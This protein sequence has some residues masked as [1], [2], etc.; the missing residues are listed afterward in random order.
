M[1]GPNVKGYEPNMVFKMK[2]Q[3]AENEGNYRHNEL[4]SDWKLS[5]KELI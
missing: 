3:V 5:L 4:V 1:K 2:M